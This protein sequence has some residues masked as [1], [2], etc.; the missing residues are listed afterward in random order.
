MLNS[1]GMNVWVYRRGEWEARSL[2]HTRPPDGLGLEGTPRALTADATVNLFAG[3]EGGEFAYGLALRLGDGGPQEWI[4]LPDLPSLLG[5]LQLLGPWLRN[6][7]NVRSFIDAALDDRLGPPPDRPAGTG[8]LRDLTAMNRVLFNDTELSADLNRILQLLS[9][10]SPKA[11]PAIEAAVRHLTAI[12]S[13]IT[14]E[15]DPAATRVDAVLALLQSSLLLVQSGEQ[16]SAV[17]EMKNA[18]AAWNLDN[19]EPLLS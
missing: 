2:P 17:A 13:Q 5:L 12:R 7:V 16:E 3:S 19:G 18:L 10:R 14:A 15:G 4:C 9:D 6:E 11:T 1:P 8:S